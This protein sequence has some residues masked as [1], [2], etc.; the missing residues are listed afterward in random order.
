M[1][2][3]ESPLIGYMPGQPTLPGR[4]LIDGWMPSHHLDNMP[5]QHFRDQIMDRVWVNT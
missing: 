3:A 5:S 1:E 4:R 2:D